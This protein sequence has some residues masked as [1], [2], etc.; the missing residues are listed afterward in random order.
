MRDPRQQKL[1]ID[2]GHIHQLVGIEDSQAPVMEFDDSV[3]DSLAHL[4]RGLVAGMPRRSSIAEPVFL[5][6]TCGV[7]PIL[8]QPATK[9]AVSYPLSA[10]TV[11]PRLA[12]LATT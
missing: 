5:L 1:R 3:L 4:Q 10:P 12:C 7:T 11:A 9:S 8:R 6:A 2:S